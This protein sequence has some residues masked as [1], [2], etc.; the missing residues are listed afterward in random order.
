MN[1]HYIDFLKTFIG[2]DWLDS[3]FNR[4]NT[5]TPL[6]GAGNHFSN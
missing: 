4:I 1:D 6:K 3:E 5:K 2:A